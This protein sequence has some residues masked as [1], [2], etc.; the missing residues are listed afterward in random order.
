MPDLVTAD[1]AE[2][3][4]T[5][6]ILAVGKR[7]DLAAPTAL[8]TNSHQLSCSNP[9]QEAGT[10]AI[11]RQLPLEHPPVDGSTDDHDHDEG[12]RGR[13]A[14]SKAEPEDHYRRYQCH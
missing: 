2:E 9:R 6:A 3:R 10:A 11:R 7:G 1:W 5:A 8:A 14:Q 4:G 12:E 13:P